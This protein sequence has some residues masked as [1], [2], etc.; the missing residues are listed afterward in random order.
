[1]KSPGQATLERKKKGVGKDV[2]CVCGKVFRWQPSRP[3]G[4]CSGVCR[5]EQTE[6]KRQ[7]QCKTCG[8]SFVAAKQTSEFCSFDCYNESRKQR[9]EV[10]CTVCGK[11]AGWRIP[12]ALKDGRKPVC[13][14]ECN[15]VLTSRWNAA[16]PRKPKKL[17][18]VTRVK[19]SKCN[20]WTENSKTKLCFFHKLQP[21]NKTQ[22]EMKWCRYCGGAVTGAR[23]E[24]FCSNQCND[25]FKKVKR[26]FTK[27]QQFG[28]PFKDEEI[29]T[30][31]SWCCVYCNVA[32]VYPF[33]HG[34]LQSATIDHVEPLSKGGLHC[35][36]NVVSSCLSCNST[37]G[38]G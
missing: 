21:S 30:R 13:S 16:Q 18:I 2:T 28:A 32:L 3:K 20:T 34:N 15:A 7:K 17:P 23:R 1:M 6:K 10:D 35:K 19:C 37:K 27:K 36:T 4:Y 14:P 38:D 9:V 22:K 12:S 26:R 25:K 11:A 5:K 29:F 33:E 24:K 31:D 8:T